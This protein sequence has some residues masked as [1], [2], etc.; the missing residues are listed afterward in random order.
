MF[1]ARVHLRLTGVGL[2]RHDTEPAQAR[3]QTRASASL[4]AS[5]ERVTKIDSDVS[6]LGSH[7]RMWHRRRHEWKRCAGRSVQR[8][9]QTCPQ[10]DLV[11]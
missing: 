6:E 11:I 3:W 4:S 10:P 7:Q 9:P 2:W 5:D 1:V 8:R